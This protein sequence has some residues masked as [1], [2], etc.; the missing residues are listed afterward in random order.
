MPISWAAYLFKSQSI[1][2]CVRVWCCYRWL[3]VEEEV[4]AS[5]GMTLACAEL[6]RVEMSLSYN[7]T[8]FYSILCIFQFTHSLTHAY[9][10]RG[11]TPQHSVQQQQQQQQCAAFVLLYFAAFFFY[12]LLFL[13]LFLFSSSFS[14][15]SFLLLVLPFLLFPL[16]FPTLPPLLSSSFVTAPLSWLLTCTHHP[17]TLTLTSTLTFKQPSDSTLLPLLQ[18]SNSLSSLIHSTLVLSFFFSFSLLIFTTTT[19]LFFSSSFIPSYSLLINLRRRN[20]TLLP[21]ILLFNKSPFFTCS[22]PSKQWAPKTTESFSQEHST[23]I[24]TIPTHFLQKRRNNNN[25][26]NNNNNFNERPHAHTQTY[27]H[28]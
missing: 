12:S 1:G 19:F 27:T 20:L 15:S 21:F 18:K 22:F 6:S 26:N 13:F 14:L 24:T 17:L 9:P 28:A 10:R 25:N 7:A 2:V 4:E 11:R 16:F 23:N 5:A 8:L 3:H